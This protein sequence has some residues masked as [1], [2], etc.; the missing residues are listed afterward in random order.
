MSRIAALPMYDFP[1]L[2][3]HTDGLWQ[4][5]RSEF[6]KIGFESE[7]ALNRDLS[8]ALLWAHP[9]LG[10]TQTCGLPYVNGLRGNATLIGTPDYGIHPGKPGWYNSVI[11][12]RQS[13]KRM[14]LA[15]FVG[16]EFAY[17]GANSQSG[18]FAIMFELQDSH[19]N[20][21]FF[22]S[23]VKSGGHALSVKAVAEGRADIAAIDAVTWRYL[24]QSAPETS[25]LK[26][27][28]AT[29]PSPGLPYISG[30]PERSFPLADAVEVAIKN[31]PDA[32][33]N[34]LGLK[35]FWRAKPEDYD[36]IAARAKL[37][38]PIMA[39]HGIS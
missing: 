33:K 26:V 1:H 36:I 9:N 31:L 19:G 8:P 5:I 29:A 10:F 39:A 30:K 7:H 23:C 22:G 25:Q 38:A 12:A 24:Q 14:A 15:E 6:Q 37:A 13:D 17:N 21:R 32:H 28:H 4:S 18:L 2:R 34:A 16:A 3:P 11:I 20:A 27:L 35:G